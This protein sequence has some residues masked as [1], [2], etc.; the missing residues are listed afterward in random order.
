VTPDGAGTGGSGAGGR[1]AG[2]ERDPKVA[3]LER[4]LNLVSYLLSARAPVP[5]SDIRAQVVGYDDEASPDAIEKRFDRDKS[6]LRQIGVV[7]EYKAEDP[8]GQP[9]YVIDKQGYFLAELSLD[10]EDAM[11]IAVLQRALGV[12]DDPLGRNLKSALAKLTIDSQL[13]EPLRASVTE[14]HLLTMGR[15]TEDPQREHLS[16]LGEAVAHRR[17]VTFRYWTIDADRTDKRTVRPFGLGLA[18][19]NWHL[20]AFD[21]DRD[22]VRNFRLDRIRGK[23]AILQRRGG[24]EFDV[25]PDFDVKAY[26]GVEEFQID[27]GASPVTVTIETD[28][29]AT[30]LLERRLRGAGRL[31]P[32]ADGTGTFEVEVKSEEGLYRWLAEFGRRVRIVSPARYAAAFAD[33]VAQAREA[34]ADVP[35]SVSA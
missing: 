20:I 2:D 22:A 14:Q 27:E 29:V 11:L 4:Q 7:I 17:R 23:V 31:T 5:F 3:K 19:G 18:D 21:E 9:G 33:R 32:R 25:P 8:T 34:Y 30:W 1:P 16:P 10:P 35:R 15:G 24:P 26:V 6:D 12:V 13:P 28:E